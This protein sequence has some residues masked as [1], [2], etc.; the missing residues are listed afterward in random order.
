MSAA[1]RNGDL[2]P[3]LL[4]RATLLHRVERGPGG[5]V[6]SE[7]PM[8][9]FTVCH[10]ITL[11]LGAEAPI[12]P[13]DTVFTRSKPDA[14]PDHDPEVV[15]YAH[16][17]M[18]AHNGTHLDSPAH[19]FPREKHLA[20]YP[21]SYFLRPARVV[22]IEDPRLVTV[23]E[24]VEVTLEPDEAILF[25]TENSRQG[26]ISCGQFREDFVAISAEAAQWCVDHAVPLVGHDYITVDPYHSY[27]APA[28][29]CLLG[30][31]IPLL[32]GVNLRNVA[33]GQYT[34]LCLPLKI[35]GAE[36]APARAVLVR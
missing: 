32:E 29:N 6:L 7:E 5:E 25:K 16:I 21:I 17:V 36:G 27:E 22:E 26:L 20:D 13:G 35:L 10:D 9:P 24:L 28:H 33:P 11:L 1:G 4:R 23:A 15:E 14:P 8:R 30:H 34:L 2:T 3:A 31:G 18:G 19:F 12:Y